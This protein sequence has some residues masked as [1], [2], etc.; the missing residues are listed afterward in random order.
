V[1]IDY[2]KAWL[3]LKVEIVQKRS[4]GA[5]DLALLMA[6]IEVGCQVPEG[7]E[8]YDPTPIRRK[9]STARP[10]LAARNG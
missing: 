4:H 8:G 9:S 7:Q 2:E 5:R 3:A 6:E 1:V 10:T